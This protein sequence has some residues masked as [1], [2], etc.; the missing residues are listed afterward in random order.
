[1]NRRA[2]ETTGPIRAT[3]VD[4][5]VRNEESAEPGHSKH[6]HNHIPTRD[7]HSVPTYRAHTRLQE[8][9]H[10]GTPRQRGDTRNRRRHEAHPRRPGRRGDEKQPT[11]ATEPRPVAPA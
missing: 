8:P 5:Q 6:I 4:A 10:P 2:C 1:M 3:Q 7:M 9:G 11:S